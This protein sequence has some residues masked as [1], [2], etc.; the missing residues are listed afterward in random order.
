MRRRVGGLA[1]AAKLMADTAIVQPMREAVGMVEHFG[2]RHRLREML[3][4]LLLIAR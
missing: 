4:R 3:L 2:Q 1:V